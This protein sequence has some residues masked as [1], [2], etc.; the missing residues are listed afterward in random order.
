MT[1]VSHLIWSSEHCLFFFHLKNI[2]PDYCFFL[3]YYQIRSFRCISESPLHF[4][5]ANRSIWIS[6]KSNAI[7][8]LL[9]HWF[10]ACRK[11]LAKIIDVYWAKTPTRFHN[12][13]GIR[14]FAIID[15]TPQLH[16]HLRQNCQRCIEVKCLLINC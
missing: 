13:N 9:M 3:M 16:D 12:K 10:V 6:G 2:H 4:K 11:F 15:C 1:N 14:M 8:S 7:H 5:V